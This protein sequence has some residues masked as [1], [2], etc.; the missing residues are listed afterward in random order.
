[1]PGIIPFQGQTLGGVV[2]VDLAAGFRYILPV[3]NYIVAPGETS[4]LQWYDSVSGIWRGVPPGANGN[5]FVRSDGAN[6]Q[7]INVSGCVIGGSVTD[8]GT[9]YTSAPAVAASNG[10]AAFTAI[11]G[12]SVASVAVGAGGGSYTYAAAIVAPPPSGGLPAEISLTLSAGAVSAATVDYAGAGYP[13]APS[14]TV[15]GDGTGATLTA[16]LSG[17]GT[18]TGLL[19]TGYGTPYT[20]AVPTLS[21][22]GGGG[23]GA[24]ATAIGA[25]RMGAVTIATAGATI[26]G[27]AIVKFEDGIIDK[28]FGRP[29]RASASA[30]ISGGA[31]TAV[32]LEDAGAFY[33]SL[34]ACNIVTTGAGTAPAVTATL[35]DSADTSYLIQV[36]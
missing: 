14:I 12:G 36:P 24:A 5:Y 33:Q 10:G 18:V 23:S 21:F 13:A 26:A 8:A 16:T 31:V 11:V 15:V 4:L 3:G 32:P 6:Y 2:P 25:Y 22:S 29:R 9:G 7:L 17:S 27:D 28:R 20:T 19:C 30:T 1:M 34:P 35:A